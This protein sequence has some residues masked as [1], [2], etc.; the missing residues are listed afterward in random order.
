[1]PKVIRYRPTLPDSGT[2]LIQQ[3]LGGVSNDLDTLDQRPCQQS[4]AMDDYLQMFSAL[5]E[6]NRAGGAGS[7]GVA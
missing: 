7:V 1:M 3:L 6:A 4:L 5:P 2:A